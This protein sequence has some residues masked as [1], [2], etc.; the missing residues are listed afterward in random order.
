M[1]RIKLSKEAAMRV[2]TYSREARDSLIKNINVM[3]RDV[4][5]Q[6]A[7][8]QDPSFKRYLDLSDQMQSMLKQIGEKMDA[9]STYCESVIRWI[10][11]Y[12][13]T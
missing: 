13:E 5:D 4:N 7:G 11:A 9:I 8:L 2:I 10:D 6:F 12:S 3:D 1:E